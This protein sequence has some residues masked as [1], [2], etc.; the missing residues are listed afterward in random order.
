[1]PAPLRPGALALALAVTPIAAAHAAVIGQTDTFQDLT[2]SGW[3]AGGGAFVATPAV[4][5]AVTASGG[6]AGAGDAF[7]LVTATGGSGPGSRLVAQNDTQWAGNYL[8]AGITGIAL[9]LR[10]FGTSDLAI[11]LEL[12]RIPDDRIITS[13]AALLPAGGG[14]T[15]VSFSLASPDLTALLGAAGD[16][17]GGLSLLRIVH[18]PTAAFTGPSV[19]VPVIAQLG[20]DNVTALGTTGGGGGIAVPEPSGLLL[21]ATGLLALGAAAPRRRLRTST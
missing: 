3:F 1:M 9:D 20:V 8:A 13:V 11:R 12:L 15:N 17:L 2:L 21:L 14:W 6:P 16:A 4:P 5:P 18:A 19:A 7:M 10:N